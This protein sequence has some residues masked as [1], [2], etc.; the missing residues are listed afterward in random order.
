MTVS[1]HLVLHAYRSS[2]LEFE[3][4]AA[5]VED[6][7]PDVR[8]FVLRDRRSYLRLLRIASRPTLLFSPTQLKRLRLLRGAVCQGLRL[9]KAEELA[10]LDA[11]GAPVPRW[12]L[13][14][15]DRDVTNAARDLG[16]YVVL[17]PNVA[18]RGAL[19]RIAR[20][21]RVRWK[22]EYAA[23]DG[24]IAQEFVYTGHWPVAYRVT[25]LFGEVLFCARVEASRERTP[26]E[27]RWEWRGNGKSVVA[28]ARDGT[29]ILDDDEEILEAGR[30]A[31]RAFPDIGLLGVDVVRDQ[32]TGQCGVIEVNAAG[33]TW[34]FT[35]PVGRQFQ[36]ENDIDFESQF[37][38]VRLAARV[39][40]EQTR[41]RAT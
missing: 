18:C 3:R 16:R 17:K 33:H 31:A 25:T 6:Y 19:V 8:T 34:H 20:A 11:A 7:A 21:G 15:S 40:A 13:L 41:R 37:D 38:G 12:F 29:W 24:L 23:Y 2:G 30:A 22:P 36:Q 4:L 26:L 32:E 10:A 9:S 39:L 28:N 14:D 5:L 1:K 35:S 27:G